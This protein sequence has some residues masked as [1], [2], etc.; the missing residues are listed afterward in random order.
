MSVKKRSKISKLFFFFVLMMAVLA[1]VGFGLTG[2][3]SQS[4]TASVATVGKVDVSADDYFRDIQNE[5][6]SVSQQLGTQLTIDQALLFGLDRTVLQRLV[7]QAAYRDE[8]LRLGVSV[9]DETVRDALVANP[10]FQG[11][12]GAFEK[13]V[14]QDAIRRSGMD[15]TQFE[16]LIRKD[17]SQRLILTAVAA[18]AVLPPEASLAIFD[19]IGEM[20]AFTYARVG[21]ANI[22]GAIL[23]PTEA[24][25][26]AYY[27]ANP[28]T[29]TQPVTRQITYVSLT[30]AMIAD[31]LEIADERIAALYEARESEF[32]TPAKR[33]VDRIV[34]GTQAEAEDAQRD[35]DAGAITFELLADSRGLALA[36]IDLGDVTARD[37]GF[38]AAA[39]LFASEEPGIYGPVETN[40]GPALFRV[41]AA[42]AELNIPLDEVRDDLR[43]ELAIEDAGYLI[44]D[45]ANNVIDL[46]AAGASLED[47]AEET[48]VQLEVIDLTEGATDGIAAYASF[49][50]EASA[51]DIGEDRDILDLEDGGIFVLRVDG[52]TEAFVKPMADVQKAVF[53]G[54]QR[55]KSHEMMIARANSIVRAIGVSNGGSLNDFAESLALESARQVTRTSTVP[56]LPSALIEEVFALEVGELAI[57]EDVLGAVII[58]L[59]EMT[60]FD[61]AD[62]QA[63]AVLEQVDAQQSRQVEQDLL[64]YF[65]AALVSAAEPTVNQT[66]I[67]TLHDQLNFTAN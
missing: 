3:F 13:T 8:A 6:S 49:R 22:S 51:A 2:I 46:I 39:V 50:E 65:A 55:A 54:Q 10:G 42:I 15:A 43:R 27:S 63:T 59:T 64:L 24:E 45:V 38:A 18:G 33:F 67:N 23:A 44:G 34:L 9:G 57:L 37:V 36:D 61:P 53:D 19:Y 12:S 35:L 32:N 21:A 31:T 62:P 41:N 58:E 40:I 28:D 17:A 7:T 52:I 11:L 16:D 26:A 60:P 4:I 25:L 66:R 47:L 20:R 1:M 29:F 48:D 14:Y 5:I 56:D 30:P